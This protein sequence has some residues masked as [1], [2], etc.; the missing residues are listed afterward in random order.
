MK[1]RGRRDNCKIKVLE[2]IKIC[3]PDIHKDGNF[4]MKTRINSEL[5]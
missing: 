1:K 2:Q 3:S 4:R 5:G